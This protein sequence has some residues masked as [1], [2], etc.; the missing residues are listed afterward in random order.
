MQKDLNKIFDELVARY[1]NAI[2]R[3]YHWRYKRAKD[4]GFI[5]DELKKGTDFVVEFSTLKDEKGKLLTHFMLW[6]KRGED[7]NDIVKH[8]RETY[9]KVTDIKPYAIIENG[10]AITLYL[11][12]EEKALKKLALDERKLM[13]VLISFIA[14]LEIQKRLPTM[15]D[16]P[17]NV[18]DDKETVA[19]YPIK[20]TGTKDNKNEFVQLIYGLHKAGFINDGTGEITKITETLAKVFNIPLGK[21]WQAN[22]SSSIHT[23]KRDY[24][25]PIFRKTQEAYKQYVAE[26]IESK[27]KKS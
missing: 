7:M 23:A 26:L 22:L 11:S 25:P 19:N 10:E 21:G 12:D 3:N 20:W 8:L 15:F 27:K 14:Y 18:K 5:K 9:G 2:E 17:I 24:E 6:Y 13:K 1:I 4:K 16:E